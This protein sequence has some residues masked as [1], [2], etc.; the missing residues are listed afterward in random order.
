MVDVCA[1]AKKWAGMSP[2]DR[3]KFLG[4]A[5][6][7]K[8]K[9]W[10]YAPVNVA[11][12]VAR[13]GSGGERQ[14]EWDYGTNTVYLDEER[15]LMN[16]DF[17]HDLK[18]AYHEA[19]HAARDKEA[20]HS[21]PVDDYK[22]AGWEFA[23][24]IDDEA[25]PRDYQPGETVPG[26]EHIEVYNAAAQMLG[27]TMAKCKAKDDY[28]AAKDLHF[29]EDDL[30]DDDEDDDDDDEGDGGRDGDHGDGLLIEWGE[31][32]ITPAP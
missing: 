12:Y 5:I 15:V 2:A 18:I 26:P 6:N 16:D 32:T 11:S 1:T 19:V 28:G 3:L 20:G 7:E 9:E 31:A 14:G 10:G 30:D 29:D 27:E 13:D 23:L 21:V 22:A 17:E 24:P 25:E 8:L 4:E